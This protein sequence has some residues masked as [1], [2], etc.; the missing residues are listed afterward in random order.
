[1]TGDRFRITSLY[2]APKYRRQG[3]GALLLDTL[4]VLAVPY[5]GGLECA[6]TVTRPDHQTLI[7]FLEREGFFPE[8]VSEAALYRA[9]LGQIA[10]APFFVGAEGGFGTPLDELDEA[11]LSLVERT[12]LGA[13]A[14][15]PEGGLRAPALDR[16][17]S[18]VVLRDHAI[19]A[20]ALVE[21]QEEGGLSLSA[22]W[23][24]GTAPAALPM[25][26]RSLL[27]RALAREGRDRLLTVQAVTPAA[28][29]LVRALLPGAEAL[30]H[31]YVRPMWR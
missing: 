14:P 29:A 26:L 3:G 1:L 28:A 23:S 25:L 27:V 17:L 30:S 12:A 11:D 2:V 18:A 8:D 16:A 22:A 9:A 10:R 7:P 20:M 4:Q 15:L 13:E 6:F 31:V 24:A 21:R 19:Q 5:S